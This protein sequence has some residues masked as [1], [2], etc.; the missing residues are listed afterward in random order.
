MVERETTKRTVALI[1]R[2]PDSLVRIIW[3]KS[4]RSCK[5]IQQVPRGAQYI[6]TL[7]TGVC[8]FRSVGLLLRKCSVRLRRAVGIRTHG[9]V[10]NEKLCAPL[11]SILHGVL[12]QKVLFQKFARRQPPQ[13]SSHAQCVFNWSDCEPRVVYILRFTRT[14]IPH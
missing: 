14:G 5:G 8:T 12:Q 9:L 2:Y 4:T 13:R 11:V 1:E 6:Q 3:L 10:L 7:V